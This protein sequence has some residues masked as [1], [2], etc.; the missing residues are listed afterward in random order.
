M[1]VDIIVNGSL[2][3]LWDINI[4]GY[5]FAAVKD[6]WIENKKYKTSIGFLDSDLYVNAGV[7]L[8]NLK[9][10]RADKVSTKFFTMAIDLA[11]VIKFQDQDILNIA[12]KGKIREID[13]IYNFASYNVVHMKKIVGKSAVII[14]YTGEDKPWE[15]NSR[16]PARRTFLQYARAM[17]SLMK[18]KIKVGLIIDE[19][20]G[21]ANTAFGGYGFLARQYIAKYIPNADISIDVLLGRGASKLFA[22]KFHEDNI[23]L[24][25]LPKSH[26][27]SR[28]WLK[29]QNYDVYISIELTS[30]WVLQHETN[31]RTKLILW[32]QDPRPKSAWDNVINSMSSIKDPCFY[33]PQIYQTVHD[34]A[35]AGRIKFISQGYTLNPLAMELYGLPS[36]T[37]IQYLPNP[38]DL[39]FKFT[40]DCTKK[41]KQIIF[42][43]RLE[44]QK[45]CWIFCEI[46]KRLPEYEFYILGQFYR[47]E[48]DNKRMLAPYMKGDIPNLH[49]LGHMDGEQKKKMI[50][51]SRVLLST[52]VWEGIP[53]SWLESL[54]Y[55]TVLVSDLEREGLVEKFGYFVGTVP[56]D[57]FEGVDKFVVGIKEMMQNDALY[58]QKA[59]AA[60][61]YT[62][63]THNIA[64]FQRDLR[65]VILDN[66]SWSLF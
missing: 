38:I 41:K 26:L 21:G 37:L 4:D 10:M 9:K 18:R 43:G 22:T 49:F 24:Y 1:D 58:M 25:L 66:T 50:R 56:G 62:R 13:C 36:K 45:R 16:H 33:N 63:K 11:D 55:G 47:Y 8:M 57:G 64:T 39:D 20:F 35:C 32:I 40:L 42:L 7:L 54:S 29:R 19:F 44:A 17:K 31:P 30:N 52:S 23:D 6:L 27:A 5:Y 15:K 46:A 2:N 28:W 14:H 65:R 60:I 59:L 61:Q 51:E 34:W 48:E 12:C 53:I 3:Q